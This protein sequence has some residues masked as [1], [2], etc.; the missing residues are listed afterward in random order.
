MITSLKATIAEQAEQADQFRDESHEGLSPECCQAK[1]LHIKSLH[2]EI[3]CLGMLHRRQHGL[4]SW[5]ELS[6]ELP[7]MIDHIRGINKQLKR[8][9]DPESPTPTPTPTQAD[10]GHRRNH[11]EPQ[12]VR[13]RPLSPT[14]SN[15]S[16]SRDS[17]STVRN[18]SRRRSSRGPAYFSNQRDWRW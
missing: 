15:I 8:L 1:L 13:P 9:R 17:A 4:N 16:V 5:P 11:S 7:T 6:G 14:G 10:T 3:A 12:N 18:E 2:E